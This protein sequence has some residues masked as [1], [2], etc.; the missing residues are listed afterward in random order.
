MVEIDF[1]FVPSELTGRTATVSFF[2]L[3]ISIKPQPSET[4]RNWISKLALEFTHFLTV[5]VHLTPI[6][7]G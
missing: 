2:R 7:K 4:V 6:N 5:N 1:P 3:V